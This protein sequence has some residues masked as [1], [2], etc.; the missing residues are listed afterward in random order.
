MNNVTVIKS[1]G[2]NLTIDFQS[3]RSDH[4]QRITLSGMEAARFTVYLTSVVH[5]LDLSEK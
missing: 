5:E 3:G 1:E 2:G 4:V